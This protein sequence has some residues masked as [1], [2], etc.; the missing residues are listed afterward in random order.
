[1]TWKHLGAVA[2]TEL[3]DARLQLHWAAQTIL[4]VADARL[5][6]AEDDS[7]TTMRW[8]DA[9]GALVGHAIDGRRLA[10][11]IAPLELAVLD[12]DGAPAATFALGGHTLDEALAWAG[13]QLGGEPALRGGKGYDMPGH[14][15]ATGAAFDAAAAPLAELARWY[16]DAFLLVTEVAAS[17][18]DGVGVACWPHHFDVGSI[19]VLGK[20][21]RGPQ[22]GIGV[23]PGDSFYPE[24]Y[25]YATPYPVAAGAAFPPLAA[26]GRWHR[27]G[28]TGAVLTGTTIAAA[29]STQ[30]ALA[31]RFFDAAVAACLSLIGPPP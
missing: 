2:P 5:P 21:L 16:A 27:A 24:P 6:L 12:A 29:G 8:D 11:R 25:L 30:H 20:N 19:F 31:R 13:A 9:S 23:S 15:V 28:F 3:G 14:A 10:L 17:R 7:H 22:I 26:G 1:M 18:P 4:A